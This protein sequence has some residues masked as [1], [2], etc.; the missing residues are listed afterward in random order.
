MKLS[1][2][3]QESIVSLLTRIYLDICDAETRFGLLV[4]EGDFRP[5]I[6]YFHDAIRAFTSEDP[7]ALEE[8]GRLCVEMLAYDLGC[9]RYLQAMPLSPFKPHATNLSPATDMIRL[10]RQLAPTATRPNR[11]EKERIG[12]LYQRYGVLFAALLKPFADRDYRDRVDALNQEVGD[13][14][15]LLEERKDKGEEAVRKL[16]ERRK[17]KDREIAAVEKAHL[18]Y[19]VAQL[20]IYE[21]AKDMVKKLAGQGM[22]LV[23][24]FV[25]A[26]VAATRSEMG[27]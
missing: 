11:V 14:K 8:G 19:A 16:K 20:A 21:E 22:N 25:E 17:Q 26:Q 10:D 2:A 4:G 24:R 7:R 6:E 23:G 13:I 9:L 18:D 27:R 1:P 3:E 15:A 5:R 12:E